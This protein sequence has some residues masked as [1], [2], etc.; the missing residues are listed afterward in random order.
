MSKVLNKKI[1]VHDF[2]L[3]ASKYPKNKSGECLTI[4]IEID[5]EKRVLFTGSDVLIEQIK[6]IKKDDFPFE[7]AIIQN[8][9]CYEFQ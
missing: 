5:N 4:Q 9:E 1:I 7:T 2:K 8:G 6:S 3:D